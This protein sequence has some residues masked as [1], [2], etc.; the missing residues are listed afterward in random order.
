MDISYCKTS[1]AEQLGR[2]NPEIEHRSFW[3]A[4]KK[5]KDRYMK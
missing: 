2:K 3:S 5:N 4:R 1:L